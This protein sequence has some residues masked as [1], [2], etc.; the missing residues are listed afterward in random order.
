MVG[1]TCEW[2]SEFEPDGNETTLDKVTL[3]CGYYKYCSNYSVVMA[4]TADDVTR[5]AVL[6][7]ITAALPPP[8]AD[9]WA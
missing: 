9:Q 3:I 2:R 6:I 4:V 5:K 7:L 8:P 1:S